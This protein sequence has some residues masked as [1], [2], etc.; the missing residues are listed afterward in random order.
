MASDGTSFRSLMVIGRDKSYA[1]CGTV[2]VGAAGRGLD[3]DD[4]GM[5]V[6][7]RQVLQCRPVYSQS[8]S[9]AW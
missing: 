8:S 2:V 4:L 5:A 7:C 3:A 1:V 6:V 9:S